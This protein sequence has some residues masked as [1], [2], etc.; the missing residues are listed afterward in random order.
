M[1]GP[2]SHALVLTNFG[3]LALFLTV[4][5]GGGIGIGLFSVPGKW[6]AGLKKPSFNP[7]N[8]IFGPVWTILY[9][10]IAIAGWRIWEIDASAIAMKVWLIQL[11]LNFTWSPLFFMAHRVGVAL[12]VIFL[13][14]ISIAAFV[15]AAWN[16]DLMSAMLF[17][18]YAIWVGFAAALNSS[19]L[20][21]NKTNSG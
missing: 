17:L 1:I 3:S 13:L 16:I 6:Y 5:V 2:A 21:L 9:V 18:P 8:W 7:P 15:I 4:V 11:V 14:F 12:A 10:F 20:Y 19:I